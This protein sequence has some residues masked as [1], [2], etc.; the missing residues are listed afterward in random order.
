MVMREGRVEPTFI[1]P[2]VGLRSLSQKQFPG[3]QQ[4]RVW[5]WKWH[6]AVDRPWARRCHRSL[7]EHFRGVF[8]WPAVAVSA[9]PRAAKLTNSANN[10][11]AGLTRFRIP[12]FLCQRRGLESICVRDSSLLRLRP[13]LFP[14]RSL[15]SPARPNPS[16]LTG[17]SFRLQRWTS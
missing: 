2:S 15:S 16:L 4:Q 6:R 1:W 10:P 9:A 5:Q 8:S 13:R 17:V 14:S 11:H 7:V 3:D 12:I